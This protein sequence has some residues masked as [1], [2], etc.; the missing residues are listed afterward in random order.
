M[1]PVQDHDLQD[2]L[3]SESKGEHVISMKGVG[4]FRVADGHDSADEQRR[5]LAKR[6]AAEVRGARNAGCIE[7]VTCTQRAQRDRGLGL[8]REGVKAHQSA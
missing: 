4:T 8:R 5:L 7:F 6:S 3:K 2:A 1:A